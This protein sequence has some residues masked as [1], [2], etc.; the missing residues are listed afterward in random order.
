MDL[1]ARLLDGGPDSPMLPPRTSSRTTLGSSSDAAPT[2]LGALPVPG[3]LS[4]S[5]SGTGL[6]L[7]TAAAAS[8]AAA[9]SAPTPATW[10]GGSRLPGG[11]GA[12][13]LGGGG[14]SL[15]VLGSFGGGLG[16]PGGFTASPSSLMT[17]NAPAT[18]PATA[19]PLTA[20]ASPAP[21]IVASGADGLR[22]FAA[23]EDDDED[24]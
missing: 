4:A 14:S 18:R 17:P 6:G 24:M 8:L 10:Q 20:G 11:L 19:L 21:M 3:M 16:R 23:D 7:G 22:L 1:S 5:N 9:A 12:L 15:M 2:P 13:S